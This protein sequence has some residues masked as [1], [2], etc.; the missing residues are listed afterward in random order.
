MSSG[1]FRVWGST[2]GDQGYMD[3]IKFSLDCDH[4]INNDYNML[5]DSSPSYG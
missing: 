3:L 2:G 5:R 4:T 1:V